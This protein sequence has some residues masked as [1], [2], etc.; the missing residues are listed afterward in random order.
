AC[1]YG[2]LSVAGGSVTIRWAEV[3]GL[4]VLALDWIERGGPKVV[5][6]SQKGFGSRLLAQVLGTP[7]GRKPQITFDERGVECRLYIGLT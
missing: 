6:P 2:A 4:D 7:S 5:P 1:K 3:E